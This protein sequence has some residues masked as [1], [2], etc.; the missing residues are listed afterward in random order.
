MLKK[1]SFFKIARPYVFTPMCLDFLH[2]GHINIIKK[3]NRY[4]NIILGLISDKGIEKY[5]HKKPINN[6]KKRKS[7][8]LMLKNIKFIIKVNNLKD[9]I[10]LSKKYKFEFIVHGDDWKKGPQANYRKQLK[11]IVS[12][13]N[14]KVIDIPYTKNISSTI[15]KKKLDN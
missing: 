12:A 6:F 9:Y 2:H 4:G 15:I 8:A 5:K 14:G 7:I 3:A 11:E 13:W 10:P 1:R